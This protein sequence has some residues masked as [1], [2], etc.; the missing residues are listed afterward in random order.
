MRVL[1]LLSWLVPLLFAVSSAQASGGGG[2]GPVDIVKLDPLVVNLAEG[3]YL[4]FTPQ[5]KLSDPHALDR[6]KAHTPLLRFLLIKYLI[7][8]PA[9]EVQT[10]Q[11]VAAFSEEAATVINKALKEELVSAVLFDGWLIQ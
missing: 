7:G 10:V 5:L 3:H 6:V 2:G 11:F 1:A 4:Q 9:K 8:R